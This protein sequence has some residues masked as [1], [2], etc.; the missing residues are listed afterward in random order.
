MPASPEKEDWKA[1]M[2]AL[3]KDGYAGKIGLETHLFDGTLI[4]AAHTS[5][6]EML[7]IVREL[8]K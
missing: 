2:A 8:D 1:I 7:R 4:A 6:Q 3:E 5:M